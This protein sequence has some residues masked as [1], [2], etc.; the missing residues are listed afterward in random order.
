M[1][2]RE[3]VRVRRV[4]DEP[5]TQDGRRVLVDRLWP[6][7]LTRDQAR[8]D[9]W[10]A[11]VAPSTQLR[12]WYDHE[13]DRYEQFIHRYRAELDDRDRAAALLH[14]RALADEG[15]LTLLTATKRSEI[16]H[17]AVLAELLQGGVEP[18]G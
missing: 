2:D 3:S 5:V 4:Y 6:R 8:I 1:T 12:R 15:T 11:Q 13:P 17:A 10:C 9:E 18:A 16:S 7:G 14:L